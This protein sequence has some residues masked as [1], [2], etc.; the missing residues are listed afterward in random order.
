MT[1]RLFS[2]CVYYFSRLH[3]SLFSSCVY[4]F[5]RLHVSLFSSCVYYFNRLHVS[6][7]SSCVY[8]FSRLHVSLFS[9][10]VYYFNRL[11]VSLFSSCVYYFN[12]LHVSLF[13]SCVYYFSRLHVSLFSSCV[14]YFNRLHVSLFSS[15]VYYFSRL[16]VSLFSSCVYYFNR[17]HVSLFSSCVYYFSRL[18]FCVSL[19]WFNLRNKLFVLFF[20][21]GR[22]YSITVYIHG[23]VLTTRQKEP[24]STGPRARNYTVSSRVTASY[25]SL[26]RETHI[27]S[28]NY[29]R[30]CNIRT[31]LY[32]RQRTW[33]E[34]PVRSRPMSLSDRRI[35]DDFVDMF[36]FFYNMIKRNARQQF[37]GYVGR[38]HRCKV[39][40]VR[41]RQSVMSSINDN[42]MK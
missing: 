27:G 42:P 23:G 10:C 15:C 37:N 38:L 39:S 28:I 35:L 36:R 31:D 14:Y 9:S 18:H 29:F 16:H 17:L 1:I 40:F 19:V 4:Y 30:I 34:R 12:R 25:A 5:N 6:L 20:Y 8:Y 41:R 11:H 33:Q 22:T 7:F 21:S 13:S 24:W 2:S 3:V 26:S 32:R